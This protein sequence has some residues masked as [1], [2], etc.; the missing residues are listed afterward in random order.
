M[1]NK[2]I[3]ATEGGK[4]IHLDERGLETTQWI[5][6]SRVDVVFIILSSTLLVPSVMV[7]SE[8]T[9]LVNCRVWVQYIV[10]L[11][12]AVIPLPGPSL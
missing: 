7:V 5:R 12:L 1:E 6:I 4:N 11:V 2:I 8:P 10:C 3:K 9:H